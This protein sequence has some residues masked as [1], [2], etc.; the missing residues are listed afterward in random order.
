MIV[1][2]NGSLMKSQKLLRIKIGNLYRLILEATEDH[3]VWSVKLLTLDGG[4]CSNGKLHIS[5]MKRTE[6]YWTLLV[7]EIPRTIDSDSGENTMVLTNNS[8]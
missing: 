6:K 5:T 1:N 3:L 4:N 7:E 8:Q 2:N